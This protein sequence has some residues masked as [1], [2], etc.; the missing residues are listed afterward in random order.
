M[1]GLNSSVQVHV[2][3]PQLELQRDS[4]CR[5]ACRGEVPAGEAEQRQGKGGAGGRAGRAGGAAGHGLAARER[6]RRGRP[7]RAQ[8]AL[9]LHGRGTR[10]A[11]PALKQACWACDVPARKAHRVPERKTQIGY[12]VRH[13]PECSNTP[14]LHNVKLALQHLH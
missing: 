11:P 6:G 2:P 13:W 8:G 14:A 7:G 12:C 10:S 4:L 5:A 9:L 3:Y 1:E